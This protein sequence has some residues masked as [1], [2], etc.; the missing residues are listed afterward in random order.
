ME[1]LRINCTR[2]YGILQSSVISIWK[3]R[4]DI[5]IID[6]T[7]KEV[8]VADA[9]IPENIWLNEREVGKMPEDDITTM[10]GIKKVTVIPVVFGALG[11]ISTGFKKYIAATGIEMKVEYAKQQP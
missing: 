5:V 9:T 4:P 3:L 7:N 8:K 1:L 6:K 11:G 10:W 2:F